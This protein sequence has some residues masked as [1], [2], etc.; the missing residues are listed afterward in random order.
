VWVD[1]TT[2]AIVKTKNES[3]KE[4]KAESEADKKE[5]KNH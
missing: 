3:A 2:G 5:K 4:E 1:A